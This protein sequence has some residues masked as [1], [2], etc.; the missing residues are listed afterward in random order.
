MYTR[1]RKYNAAELKKRKRSQLSPPAPTSLSPTEWYN[2]VVDMSGVLDLHHGITC[3]V[4]VT[5]T[6]ITL[7]K[8]SLIPPFTTSPAEPLVS[9]GG[10]ERTLDAFSI[11]DIEGFVLIPGL[12]NSEEQYNLAVRCLSQYPQPPNVTNL[13][14][15]N[16]GIQQSNLWVNGETLEGKKIMDSLRWATLGYH[17]NWTDRC[18]DK[19][20]R[21]DIPFELSS[22]ATMIGNAVGQAIKAEAVIVNYYALDSV[23]GA[24]RDELEFTFDHPVISLSVGSSAIFLLGGPTKNED[25]IPLLLRSG[26]VMVMGGRSRLVYHG[27]PCILERDPSTPL[28]QSTVTPLPSDYERVRRYLSTMRINLNIRQV[29]P[30][31]L[32]FDQALKEKPG[33]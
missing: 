33:V 5:K 4:P 26:D 14:S 1:Y 18:Y 24:H 17:Y 28:P 22:L 7:P 6:T 3:G 19:N 23:M 15:L 31:G 9:G 8:P 13:D 25:P 10:G 27:V 12:L 16:G 32:D 30:V 2:A 11:G 21:H 29:V 20:H